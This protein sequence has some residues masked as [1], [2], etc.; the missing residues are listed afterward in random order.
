MTIPSRFPPGTPFA[1]F[2]HCPRCGSIELSIDRERAIACGVCSFKYF[3]NCASAV[4]GLLL[5]QGE[6]VLAVRGREPQ[7][8]MLDLPGGFI[9][10]NESVEEALAREI[11]EELSLQIFR[12]TYLTS[13]PNDYQ[14]AGVYYKTTDLFFICELEDISNIQAGDDVESYLLISP[15]DL[16]PQRLAFASGRVALQK[17][18]DH[19]QNLQR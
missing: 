10:F 12:S 14:Y 8:G 15:Y 16:D 7:K 3:F 17:L 4:A 13:A 18:L 19:L 11:Y 2:A 5:Y 9:E 6:L 1:D